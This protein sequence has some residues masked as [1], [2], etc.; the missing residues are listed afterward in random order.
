MNKKER[1]ED[2]LINK[3]SSNVAIVMAMDKMHTIKKVQEIFEYIFIS[4]SKCK[5]KIRK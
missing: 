1:I 3:S 5:S 4:Q 2:E